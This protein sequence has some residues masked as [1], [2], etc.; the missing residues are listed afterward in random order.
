TCPLLHACT[1]RVLPAADRLLPY[2]TLFRSH[3]RRASARLRL[4]LLDRRPRRRLEHRLELADAR[5]GPEL[6]RQARD[7]ALEL[8]RA[9][10]RRVLG[11][12][13]VCTP[14]TWP[15]RMPS[16]PRRI[17]EAD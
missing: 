1:L 7:R 15:A 17:L 3:L 14:V 6:R 16:P 13:H 5:D 2:T 11:M 10:R 9:L 8:R 4:E 12:A